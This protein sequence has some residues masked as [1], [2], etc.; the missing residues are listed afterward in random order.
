MEDPSQ[1]GRNF[2]PK[3]PATFSHRKMEGII[4]SWPKGIF[5][6]DFNFSMG[7]L[8]DASKSDRQFRL[9]G[10]PSQGTW[11]CLV[12]WLVGCFFC[13][14]F[15]PKKFSQGCLLWSSKP[16]FFVKVLVKET[17]WVSFFNDV[18]FAMQDLDIWIKNLHRTAVAEARGSNFHV[19]YWWN[20]AE[21]RF[22]GFH[23]FVFYI[24]YIH[25]CLINVLQCLWLLCR[26]LT[27]KIGGTCFLTCWA[28]V[29][30]M[31]QW[32]WY[33]FG[34]S[35]HILCGSFAEA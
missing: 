9:P 28:V 4:H 31:W 26:W 12:G 18:I 33:G 35:V 11:A 22:A 19:F 29:N 16:V 10:L 3:F 23:D 34:K 27:P 25:R 15:F 7:Q 5:A 8:V 17:T 1:A 32:F 6:Y 20:F 14:L 24:S 13:F 30:T 21:V 2:E